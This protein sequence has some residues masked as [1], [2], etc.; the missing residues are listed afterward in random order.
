MFKQDRYFTVH[1]VT[2]SSP[3][4]GKGLKVNF[5]ITSFK[6]CLQSDHVLATVIQVSLLQCVDGCAFRT[7]CRAVNYLTRYHL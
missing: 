5:K 6:N 3:E 7:D 2:E 4:T 1:F